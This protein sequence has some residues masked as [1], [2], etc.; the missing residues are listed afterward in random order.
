MSGRQLN[1]I[2]AGFF[3]AGGKKDDPAGLK[4]LRN[5]LSG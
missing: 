4:A 3:I 1:E 5:D 2:A